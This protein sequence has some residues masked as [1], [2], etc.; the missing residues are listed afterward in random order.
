MSAEVARIADFEA[1]LLSDRG[2]R[3]GFSLPVASISGGNDFHGEDRLL[4]AKF[5]KEKKFKTYWYHRRLPFWFRKD[6][7]RADGVNTEPEVIRLEVAADVTPNG[8]PPVR[9]FLG[10]ENAQYRPERV[11]VWSIM[12][13]RNPARVYE[14]HLMKDLKGIDRTGWKT[15]F[16]NYRY[17]IPTLAGGQGRAIYNDVDQIYLADPGIL[18]DLDMKGAGMLGITERETSVM[19]IDCEKMVQYW[20]MDDVWSNKRHRH[21]RAITHDNNLWGKLPGEWNARDDEYTAGKSSCFHFT[22][23]QTQPWRP[24]PDQIRYRPHPDGAV[25]FDL[26][27]QADRAGFTIFTKEHPSQ[28]FG[29]LLQ[30]NRVMHEEGEKAVGRASEDTFRG[31]S[32]RKHIKRIARLVRETGARTILDYG[33]GKATLYEAYPGEPLESRYRSHPA[34]PGVKVVCYDPGYEPFAAPFSERCD[35][36]ISTDVLEHIPAGDIGWVLDEIFQA[37]NKFVYVVAACYPARKFLPDGQNAHCTVEPPTWWQGQVQL[38]ARRNP[39]IYWVLAT[40]EKTE[41]GKKRPRLFK[42]TGKVS[43]AA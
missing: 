34:W 24:L 38:A 9:I 43:E 41:S 18:F 2:Y 22:T 4:V 1:L 10:T 25:W 27:A 39:G 12:Q 21:F 35:G 5:K 19:L 6:R 29:E 23:L 17:T 33:A 26:E 32:L 11:F 42:G 20:R 8:K 15:G 14:I 40:M 30:L 7:D 13:V 31:I 3:A 16:T 36:V 28:R 37:S